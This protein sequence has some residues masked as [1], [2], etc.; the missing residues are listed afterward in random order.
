[1]ASELLQSLRVP[2]SGG[3]PDQLSWLRLRYLKAEL[4]DN[5]NVNLRYIRAGVKQFVPAMRKAIDQLPANANL[6]VMPS[7][8]RVNQVPVML[9]REIAKIRPDLTLL[10]LR[11]RD[12]S[13]AHRSES[14]IKDDYV[15]R[16]A[17]QRHF[18][19]SDK[20]TTASPKLSERPLFILDDSIS[21]GDSAIMLHR[22]LLKHNIEAKGI[23]TAL[24]GASYA[25]AADLQRLYK[26]IEPHRPAGLSE[27]QL[28][29]DLVTVFGG[30]PRRKAS[31]FELNIKRG[32]VSKQGAFDYINRTARYLESEK[33]SP[34]H[35]LEKK[36]ELSQQASLKPTQAVPQT[37]K[38]RRGPKL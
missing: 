25:T 9:A 15:L 14:K 8:T 11:Y 18:N 2:I 21:T 27:K 35:V 19:F 36:K 29:K 12:V 30:F 38:V 31:A 5:P 6:L 17:D 20:F 16:T 37:Q 7:T 4:R 22:E 33:L 28:Q 32:K 10:N 1:M 34:T 24:A 26:Q 3:K 13:V 23:V